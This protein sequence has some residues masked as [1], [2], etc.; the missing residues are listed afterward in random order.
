MRIA[1]IILPKTDNDGRSMD[2]M[3]TLYQRLLCDT[4]GGF[5]AYTVQ[6]GWMNTQGKLYLDNNIAYHIAMDDTQTNRN[7]L[8]TIARNATIE[9][10]QEAIFVTYA[11]GEV[12]FVSAINQQ[13]EEIAA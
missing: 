10:S 13:P 9:F 7:A 4:F 12:A 11:N 8:D 5:T 3:H 6:G 1:Q 2:D